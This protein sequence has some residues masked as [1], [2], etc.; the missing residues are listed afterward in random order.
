MA[1]TI[2]DIS[3]RLPK[4]ETV[5]GSVM[6]GRAGAIGL[7]VLMPV[8]N[9]WESLEG[10]LQHLDRTLAEQGIVASV[11]VVDDGSSIAVPAELFAHEFKALARIEVLHLRR[12]LG[13]QRAIAIGLTFLYSEAV[14]EA[15]VVMDADGQDRPED[16]PELLRK[17]REEN[18]R[19]IVFAARTRRSESMLFRLGYH[20]YRGLHWLLT[21]VTVRVGNFSIVPFSSL[22]S[23]SVV[24]ELWNHYSAAVFRSRL[25]YTT[26]P[27]PRARR[28]VGDPRMNV[29]QL[30]LH[31]LSA[32][33]V[34]GEIIGV[35]L[36]IAASILL[37]L[38][39]GLLIV[40]FT[41][42]ILGAGP[43]PSWLLFAGATLFL[44]LVEVILVSGL[45]IVS[46]LSSRA[47]LTFLPIRDFRYFVRNTEEVF[48]RSAD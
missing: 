48:R 1:L 21:G 44:L 34:Y 27:A 20:A 45:L 43:G 8:F 15:V 40:I 39:M 6:S 13:H 29:F 37:V 28:T 9:D 4:N 23:L 26:I 47:T 7:H 32:L 16:V 18:G 38:D 36:L 2:P 42:H 17:F 10:T 24:A 14:C 19:K 25:P 46:M 31:G 30:V 22:T 33:S 35:R 3:A 12:N 5:A 11:L 41:R